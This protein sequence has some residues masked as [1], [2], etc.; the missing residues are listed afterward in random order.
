MSVCAALCAALCAVCAVDVQSIGE[1]Q[2]KEVLDKCNI[3][4]MLLLQ[5]AEMWPLHRLLKQ[6]ALPRCVCNFVLESN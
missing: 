3:I 2:I 1:I 5:T 4:P 6:C